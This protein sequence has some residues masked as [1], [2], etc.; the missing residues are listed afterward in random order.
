MPLVKGGSKAAVSQNI[1]TEMHA[2]RP[3]R[4]SVAIAMRMAGKAKPKKKGK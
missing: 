4:Q 3:Q 2:G 1:R